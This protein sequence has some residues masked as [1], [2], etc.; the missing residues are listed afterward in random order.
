MKSLAKFIIA[1]VIFASLLGVTTVNSVTVMAQRDTSGMT[2]DQGQS[3]ASDQ[4]Q[5]MAS[6]QGQSMASDQQQTR[7][8]QQG[9]G[10][11]AQSGT[12]SL[13][14]TPSFWVNGGTKTVFLW[15]NINSD[16]GTMDLCAKT[17]FNQFKCFGVKNWQTN[18]GFATASFFVPS[19]WYKCFD[20][21]AQSSV[22]QWWNPG[23]SHT[24][25][26]AD[27]FKFNWHA[28]PVNFGTLPCANN[29]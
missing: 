16:H 8:L 22:D 25:A 17:S 18:N 19:G 12:S 7:S 21:L 3:M 23:V 13:T 29:P 10:Q 9:Q 20:S 4:G 1:A 14:S 6:D 24:S 28:P 27:H 2:S 26:F 15:D 5:S 11:G